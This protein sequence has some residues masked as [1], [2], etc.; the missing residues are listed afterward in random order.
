[1]ALAFF[2]ALYSIAG[3]VFLFLKGQF[4]WFTYP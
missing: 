1:M 2:I 3:S 4:F